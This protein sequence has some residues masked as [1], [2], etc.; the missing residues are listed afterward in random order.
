MSP[1]TDVSTARFR[2]APGLSGLSLFA[3]LLC[4]AGPLQVSAQAGSANVSAADRSYADN[5]IRPGDMIKLD[6]WREP[7]LSG[8][9]QVDRNGIVVLP[10]VGRYDVSAETPESLETKVVA[11]MQAEI[12]NPSIDVTVLRRVR[13]TGF[14]R[15]GGVF[16]L[17]PTMTVADA[18]AMAGGLG[19]D[20]VSDRVLLFRGG[21]VVTSD[22]ELSTSIYETAI[23]SGD[24][25]RVPQRSWFSRNSG[26]L[27]TGASAFVG[28]LITLIATGN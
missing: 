27:I 4:V 8:E 13:V 15:E 24:E 17:D 14:V 2:I 23:R 12:E 1:R 28:I 18:L 6:V 11:A 26:S 20:G 16:A 7:D 22:L 10:L 19:R 5:A 3:L 9:F 21:R 25:L